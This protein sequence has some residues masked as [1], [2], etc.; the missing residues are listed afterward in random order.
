MIIGL[1]TYKADGSKFREFTF[2]KEEKIKGTFLERVA[3]LKHEMLPQSGNKPTVVI[4]GAGPAGLIRAITSILNGNP[5]QIIEKRSESAPRRENTV[6]LET[7]TVYQLLSL[8]VYQYLAEHNM[9]FPA[10]MFKTDH[11]LKSI[12]VRLGDLE[13]AL[14]VLIKELQPTQEID[15]GKRLCEIDS[16]REKLTLTIESADQQRTIIENVGILVNAEGSRSTTNQL[17]GICRIKVLPEKPAIAVIFKDKRPSINGF[18]SL[19]R[20]IGISIAYIAK[21]VYYHAIFIFKFIFCK[22][23]RR[24]C[25]GVFL[26]TP[27]QVY[28]GCGFSP[29]INERIQQFKQEIA[30]KAKALDQASTQKER[31]RCQESLRAAK[32]RYRSFLKM[33]SNLGLCA[34]NFIN[35]FMQPL[36]EKMT[37]KHLSF[38]RCEAIDIGAD[39][40]TTFA[41]KFNESAILL[42]GDAAATVDPSTGLG[43]NTALQS[44]EQFANFIKDESDLD[45]INKQSLDE[46]I[47]HYQKGINH[48]VEFIHEQSKLSREVLE[49][50][51]VGNY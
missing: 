34:V 4:L 32:K 25:L 22:S 39:R 13:V 5:T 6:L 18:N 47:D 1:S 17:L 8:G 46:K 38:A 11:I 28:L 20:Y 23:F 24:E 26:K 19:F 36:G 9:I 29:E 45:P 14:K 27:G 43:C 51:I 31:A 12:E 16:R 44:N 7:E 37:T 41:L 35:L 48:Y 42:A 2:P 49:N 33:R 21:T 50:L 3:A 30:N 10:K 15:Y 40:A